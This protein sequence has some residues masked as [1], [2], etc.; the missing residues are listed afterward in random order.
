MSLD[1]SR[2]RAFSRGRLPRPDIW[3]TVAWFALLLALP[4]AVF[5]IFAFYLFNADYAVTRTR[6][7][8][9]A[10][11]Q[12]AELGDVASA[13]LDA[14]AGRALRQI[15]TALDAGGSDM[16]R[17]VRVASFVNEV[18]FLLIYNRDGQVI[19]VA[20][21]TLESANEL[22]QRF[23]NLF[24]SLRDQMTSASEASRKVGIWTVG[25]TL[26][27]FAQC[28]RVTASRDICL[29]FD[30]IT[31]DPVLEEALD[32]ASAKLN[33][34]FLVLRDPL[35]R[36]L[37]SHGPPNLSTS[38]ISDLSGSMRGWRMET[39]TPAVAHHG[40]LPLIAI[41]VPL[42]GSWLLLIWYMYRSQ[43]ARLLESTFRS[44]MTAKLSHD[45]RTPIA[46][47]RLYTD[48]LLRRSDDAAAVNRY[49]A[50][51]R[52]EVERLALLADNTIVYG[53]TATP[54]PVRLEEAV[55]DGVVDATIARYENLFAAG[56]SAIEVTHGAA[57]PGRFDRV[58]FERILV[59]LIDNANKY[60]PGRILVST[61]VSE[62]R[63]ILSV[64]DFGRGLDPSMPTK[65]LGLVQPGG[66]AK[67][68]FGLGLVVV[69]ELA[70]ANGGRVTIENAEPGLRVT[71]SMK[72]AGPAEEEGQCPS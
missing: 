5:G 46:N 35:G 67:D 59:N 64:R 49:G 71:V 25:E 31:L 34:R 55:P 29:I 45:L 58:S 72:I 56:G 17:N 41:T 39:S 66:G 52:A 1:I 30:E 11:R 43:Q 38:T 60:A 23:G 53:R 63:L 44:E 62:G 19:P 13:A 65:M 61:S 37:W 6:E 51:M 14:K 33:D 54:A 68:G 40:L 47:L 8:A 4:L 24:A 22:S 3:R 69:R 2:R 27:S 12:A 50:V 20:T 42:I 70:E 28:Q 36:A 10:A 15:E 32:T 7:A 26:V 9:Q 18:R 21:G 16:L 48:L 57:R